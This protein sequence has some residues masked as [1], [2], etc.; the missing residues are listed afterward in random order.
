MAN[1]S[2]IDPGLQALLGTRGQHVLSTVQ[3]LQTTLGPKAPAPEFLLAAIANSNRSSWSE[4]H[5]ER[6]RKLERACEMLQAAPGIVVAEFSHYEIQVGT[7]ADNSGLVL[8]NP[9]DPQSPPTIWGTINCSSHAE[10][11]MSSGGW[12]GVLQEI[13]MGT[14]S[15]AALRFIIHDHVLIDPDYELAERVAA[16]W[17]QGGAFI[18]GEAPLRSFLTALIHREL[19]SVRDRPADSVLAFQHSNALL[20]ISMLKEQGWNWLPE[21]CDERQES[22]RELIRKEAGKT[23]AALIA[24]SIL[25]ETKGWTSVTLIA[26]RLWASDLSVADKPGICAQA[27]ALLKDDKRWEALELAAKRSGGNETAFLERSVENFFENIL[28]VRS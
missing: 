21:R 6:A 17:M 8:S 22:A 14:S 7:T 26:P 9:H 11:R 27:R 23:A 20:G 5:L 10:A 13:E 16:H 28:G 19:G 24:S 4:T 2:S 15:N 18:V 1:I 12:A 25:R 3:S